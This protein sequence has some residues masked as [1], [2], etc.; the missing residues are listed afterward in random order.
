MKK[1][2][3]MKIQKKIPIELMTGVIRKNIELE[4]KFEH[5]FSPM[6]FYLNNQIDLYTQPQDKPICPVI[7]EIRFK[8]LQLITLMTN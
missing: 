3:L 8:V 5:K 4:R 2:I 1:Q 7:K 6:E